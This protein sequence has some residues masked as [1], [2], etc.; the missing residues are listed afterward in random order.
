MKELIG[1]AHVAEYF[2]QVLGQGNIAHAYCFSGI[3]HVGKT[4]VA[5]SIAAKLLACSKDDL[6]THADMVYV[7]QEK[8]QKTGKTKK[9]IDIAQIRE[10]NKQ[11]ARSPALG[12]RRVVIINPADII[13]EAGFNALLKTIEEPRSQTHFFF[14]AEN[15]DAVPKT[16]QSRCQHVYFSVPSQTDIAVLQEGESAEEWELKYH[17]ARGLPGLLIEWKE[18]PEVYQE[19]KREVARCE[20]LFFTCFDEKLRKVEDM[21]GDKTDHISTRKHLGEVIDI[22]QVVFRYI[23]KKNIEAQGGMRGLSRDIVCSPKIMKELLDML[24][25][26]KDLL[27]KNIHPKALFE[28]LLLHIP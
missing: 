16:I 5:E 25:N 21:F 9:Y 6:L 10:L 12:K 22:W 11:V 1:H 8:H 3:S 18:K 13:N 14:L 24:D 20:Q 23:M 4:Y 27:G 19:V 17:I 26:T 7:S 15:Y 28:Q 2:S